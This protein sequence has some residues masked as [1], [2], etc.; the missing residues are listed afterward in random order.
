M[1]QVRTYKHYSDERLCT[2]IVQE[3]PWY[4]TGSK[5]DMEDML[6]E[7]EHRGLSVLILAR[8]SSR[9][10]KDHY[11]HVAIDETETIRHAENNSNWIFSEYYIDVKDNCE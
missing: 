10:E 2:A 1:N 3:V 7:T 11:L 8:Y 4:L 9:F 5:N 6:S